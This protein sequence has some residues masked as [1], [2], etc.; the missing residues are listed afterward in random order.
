MYDALLAETTTISGDGGDP[1]EAYL[2]RTMQSGPV[3]GVV[4][5][6]HLPGYDSATKGIV[7][8]FADAGYN[9]IMPNLFHREAPG[10][11][12]DDAYATVRAMGG[13]PDDRVVGDV[14]AARD[15]LR[16]L[17]NS[18][19]KVGVIG[20]CSG[21]RQTFLVACSTDFDAAVDCYGGAVLN[22]PRAGM[23]LNMVPVIDL[24]PN[25]SCPLLG[26]FGEE[27]KSPSPDETAKISA[28][29]DRL[30]KEHEFHTYPN[31]GHGFFATDRPMYRPEAATEGW[32]TLLEFYGRHLTNQGA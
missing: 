24:A 15:Y 20:F 13:V 23:G 6:H 31:A 25:L 1:V 14:A 17:T 16:G 12:P 11:A 30:G 8:R 26:L 9:A 4:V 10:A 3:G 18:N 19:G 7:R 22:A 28:E 2:A 32:A 5:I 21:G 29:L 27:D